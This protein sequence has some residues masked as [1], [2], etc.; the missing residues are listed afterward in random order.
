M[1]CEPLGTAYL[2]ST[3]VTRVAQLGGLTVAA[4]LAR[5]LLAGVAFAAGVAIWRGESHGVALAT[6]FY[7]ASLVLV[8]LATSTGALPSARAPSEARVFV[9]ELVAYHLGCLAYL[10]WS[11]RVRNL[12][13]P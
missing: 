3:L 5:L 12:S 1:V 10:R 9:V 2:A 6:S 4:L 13:A 8:L 11:R 7:V